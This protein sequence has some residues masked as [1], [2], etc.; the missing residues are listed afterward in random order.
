MPQLAKRRRSSPPGGDCA[1]AEA[2]CE[3]SW[4]VDDD[5]RGRRGSP[6]DDSP[7]GTA[8]AGARERDAAG[9]TSEVMQDSQARRPTFSPVPPHLMTG[10]CSLCAGRA[11]PASL[12]FAARQCCWCTAWLSYR[13]P[14]P[15]AHSSGLTK[16]RG[17]RGRPPRRCAAVTRTQGAKRAAAQAFLERAGMRRGRVHGWLGVLGHCSDYLRQ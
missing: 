16:Y 6:Y 8:A 5:A 13:L 10:R 7:P 1:E 11:A 14:N 2:A 17:I 15:D 3:G 12:L 9:T 4:G